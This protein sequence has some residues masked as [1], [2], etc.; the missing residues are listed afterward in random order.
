MRRRRPKLRQINLRI[1]EDLRRRLETEA[2]NRGVSINWLMRWL[3][4]HGLDRLD[5][6]GETDL[7]VAQYAD[8]V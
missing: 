6:I 8:R 3:L 2:E 1:T 5:K 4:Q 7:M